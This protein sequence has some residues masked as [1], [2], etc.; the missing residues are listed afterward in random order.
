M[1]VYIQA[2][3]SIGKGGA[4]PYLRQSEPAG[5][6]GKNAPIFLPHICRWMEKK[7]SNSQF[8]K[9]PEVIFEV[10]EKAG[11]TKEE[12]RLLHASS[13]KSENRFFCGK[14]HERTFGKVSH[15]HRKIWEILPLQAFRFLLDEWNRRGKLNPGDWIVLSGFGGGLTY[16]A[17]LMRW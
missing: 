16:G 1:P 9:V 10:L 2:T 13:G 17:S 8:P 3:H 6:C 5:I 11:K 12:I 7:C 15:E 14:A 4:C